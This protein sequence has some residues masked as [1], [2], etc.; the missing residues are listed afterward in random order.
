MRAECPIFIARQIMRHR[1]FSFN[2]ISGRY[3]A[4][5]EDVWQPAEDRPLHND[6]TSTSPVMVHL[7][8]ETDEDARGILNEAADE[9]ERRYQR[10]LRLGVANEV[11]RSVLPVGQ[12]TAFYITGN[13]VA[14][15]SLLEKRTGVVGHPQA[16]A[17]Q[18]ARQAKDILT[19]IYPNV[20]REWGKKYA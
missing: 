19:D 6:G 11:A 12:Y 1:H 17:K 3:S 8:P 10:L 7:D 9:A 13:L 20:I 2:E 15:L 16:E 5:P 14:W 4:M 18:L